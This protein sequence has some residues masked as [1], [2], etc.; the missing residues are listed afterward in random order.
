MITPPIKPQNGDP[1]FKKTKSDIVIR[2]AINAPKEQ[3][4]ENATMKVFFKT[5]KRAIPPNVDINA[6][7]HVVIKP[8]KN[9]EKIPNTMQS[10]ENIIAPV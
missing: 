6:G 10:K 9:G 5:S 2:K 8:V 4:P 7:G 3:F 1:I